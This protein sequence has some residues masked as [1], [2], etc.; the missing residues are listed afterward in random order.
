MEN[1]RGPLHRREVGEHTLEGRVRGWTAVG[2]G[3]LNVCS[4][5]ESRFPWLLTPR[6]FPYPQ[7][8]ERWE[9]W[10]TAYQ[11]EVVTVHNMNLST[12]YL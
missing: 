3:L 10:N 1:S 2:L 6:L 11:A 5:T 7:A 9:S 4:R 8:P 12:W